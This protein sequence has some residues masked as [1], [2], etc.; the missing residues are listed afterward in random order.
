MTEHEYD[1]PPLAELLSPVEIEALAEECDNDEKIYDII[2]AWGDSARR[3]EMQEWALDFIA[4]Q[5][6]FQI[7]DENTLYIA[8]Y[9][10]KGKGKS[11]V[12]QRLAF[13]LIGVYQD[14][15][16]NVIGVPK[17]A[18]S[19]SEANDIFGEETLRENSACMILDE[20][21]REVSTASKTNLD[22]LIQNIDTMRNLK[23]S[24]IMITIHKRS[25]GGLL[26]RCE[27]VFRA[28]FKDKNNRVNWCLMF[29]NDMEGKRL[30]PLA[31]VGIELHPFEEFREMYEIDKRSRQVELTGIGGG[32]SVADPK[33][34]I[35]TTDD[36][37]EF[38]KAKR[39][40]G[41]SA[42][43]IRELL[44]TEI[45]NTLIGEE[46]DAVV[47]R[48]QRLMK[49]Q[50]A[51]KDSWQISFEGMLWAG[52]EFDWRVRLSNILKDSTTYPEEY[53]KIW[54]VIEVEGLTVHK[55]KKKVKEMV[56]MGYGAAR[57][58]KR[59]IDKD[60]SFQGWVKFIRGELF[61]DFLRKRFEVLKFDAEK[62]PTVIIDGKEYV[63]DLL[64]TKDG[65]SVYINAKCGAGYANY[66][67]DDYKTTHL[68]KTQLK[69]PAWV[70]YYDYEAEIFSV[71]DPAEPTINVGS[72]DTT[73]LKMF[74]SDDF[75]KYVKS[76]K[77][78]GIKTVKIV[79][80]V[81]GIGTKKVNSTPSLLSALLNGLVTL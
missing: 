24:L 12:A 70:V 14:H 39:I 49:K 51:E 28:L 10:P 33:N 6:E 48:T 62:K 4:R 54:Y 7:R 44:L 30:I 46:K 36:V 22:A 69:Q 38:L 15:S 9:G 16:V 53:W 60:D 78:A 1:I 80:F 55:D 2:E 73:T 50:K 17:V 43:V 81:K 61:E 5:A 74:E 32:R 13:F 11:E 71:H 66:V 26:P 40:T 67:A 77:G 79:K 56:G 20:K 42:P 65:D 75:T 76:T 59:R 34:V 29:V 31:I 68:I 63:E 23:H 52:D 27:L 45:P 19:P 47:A 57:K 18:R 3:A 58:W 8:V 25:F 41:P 64:V 21:E 37:I 35:K 72:E